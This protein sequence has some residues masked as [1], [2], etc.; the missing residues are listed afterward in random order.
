MNKRTLPEHKELSINLVC[1]F[2]GPALCN[3]LRFGK[4]KL[5]LKDFFLVL[6]SGRSFCAWFVLNEVQPPIWNICLK[7][8][9]IVELWS[10]SS[11]RKRWHEMRNLNSLWKFRPI[12]EAEEVPDLMWCPLFACRHISN[13]KSTASVPF[14][15]KSKWVVPFPSKI[16]IRCPTTSFDFCSGRSKVSTS[17]YK[18]NIPNLNTLQ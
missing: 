5:S 10:K 16:Y 17:K 2:A 14:S 15:Q 13:S 8:S 18:T 11:K 6:I 12:Y 7:W 4:R 9:K 3:I 1:P